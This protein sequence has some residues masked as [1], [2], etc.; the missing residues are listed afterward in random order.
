MLTITVINVSQWDRTQI[1]VPNHA[2]SRSLHCC[3]PMERAHG[4][5]LQAAESRESLPQGSPMRKPTAARL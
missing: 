5:H 1:F 4:H 3:S 2:G